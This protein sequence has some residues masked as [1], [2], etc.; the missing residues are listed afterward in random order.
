MRIAR[1]KRARLAAAATLAFVLCLAAVALAQ[2]SPVAQPAVPSL[3][4]LFAPGSIWIEGEATVKTNVPPNPWLKGDNLKLLSGGDAL[5]GLVK[6][7]ALPSPCFA[8][9]KFDCPASGDYDL[10]F[11]HG[12][13]DNIGAMRYRFVKLGADGTPVARP[14]DDEGW[15]AFDLGVTPRD[16][17]QLGLYRTLEWSKQQRV[18]LEQGTYY[19]DLQ[20]TGPNPG[21]ASKPDADIWIAIDAI[22]LT[23]QPVAAKWDAA[24]VPAPTSATSASLAQAQAA[25][26]AQAA[27]TFVWIEGEAAE[28][29]N[30]PA[31]G[32]NAWLKGDDPKLLSGGD[33]LA[34]LLKPA[35]LP[36]PC[37]ALYRFDC[38]VEHTY[39][40]Y[41]RHGT[42]ANLAAM[43]YR[44]VKLG[45]DGNALKEPG[46]EEGWLRFDRDAAVIESRFIGEHRTI[47]WSKQ[48]QVR[49][50]A[51]PYRLDLQITGKNPAWDRT[52]D[53][54]IE[55][56]AICL[57]AGPFTPSG[58]LKP[59][60]KPEAAGA[61]A[62]SANYY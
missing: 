32:A 20:I 57:T 53:I 19:L 43:R 33:A 13:R 52:A 30:I 50:A 51:G 10:Y 60:E 17:Q 14:G 38:P 44:F 36:S 31:N 15:L 9:Y 21:Q 26:P 37:F 22:C 61:P 47:E 54:W 23:T 25:T 40:V 12:Y 3:A 46:V 62:A 7:A 2:S 45:A 42:M 24:W 56:D 34:G 5:T 41:L 28:K 1:T 8:L 55:I 39:D 16:R 11:R 18:A 35:E 6:P 4:G 59:G 58:I 48:Q 49:L 27:P 29:T